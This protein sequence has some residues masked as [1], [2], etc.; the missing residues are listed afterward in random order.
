MHR[1][2]VDKTWVDQWLLDSSSALPKKVHERFFKIVRIK[3]NEIVGLFDGEGREI[4]AF[5]TPNGQLS[6]ASLIKK[7]PDIHQCTL[8][9]AALE[10][11]KISQTIKRATEFGIN[12][13][14]IFQAE[15]S[16]SFCFG[17]LAKRQERLDSLCI[18][19][20]RQSGRLFVPKIVLIKDL[21][22]VLLDLGTNDLATYGDLLAEHKFSQTL[23]N[24][25]ELSKVVL[26]VGPEGGLSQQEKTLLNMHNFKSVLWAPHT[27]RS[28]FAC[29]SALC[30]LNAYWGKA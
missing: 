2:F 9:Q 6:N 4:Q 22:S 21:K 14:I 17:K 12:K 18:D 16:D 8:I 11:A 27:L 1:C 19:A 13:I 28:E 20:A 29:L 10:E 5:L 30:I 23:K 15:L 25:A 24:F 26:A 3:K 7:K